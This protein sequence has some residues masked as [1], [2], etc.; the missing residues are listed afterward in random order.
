MPEE[1]PEEVRQL[2]LECL[3]SKPSLRPSALRIAERLQ[4]LPPDAALP[5]APA[6]WAP[7]ELS[8]ALVPLPAGSGGSGDGGA[9]GGSGESTPAPESPKPADE[10]PSS[11]TTPYV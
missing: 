10:V 8:P 2:I 3:E 11:R 6:G 1:C 7:A 4:A 5:P 9:A